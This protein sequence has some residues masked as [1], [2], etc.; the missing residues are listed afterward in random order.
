MWARACLHAVC[1][2]VWGCVC[3]CGYVRTCGCST[4][5]HSR[6]MSFEIRQARIAGAARV[7]GVRRLSVAAVARKKTVTHTGQS[8]DEDDQRN[9]RFMGGK[10]MEVCQ[11]I[12]ICLCV[13]R[14]LRCHCP[15]FAFSLP[16]VWC[17][18]RG[19]SCL[20]LACVK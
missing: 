7:V 19:W 16:T 18:C 13:W 12:C 8:F 4:L 1:V 5:A 11:C 17:K 20:Q 9:L 6:S 2:C 10:S 14:D 15:C 3:V